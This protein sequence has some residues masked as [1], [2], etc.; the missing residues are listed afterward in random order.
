MLS[1]NVSNKSTNND[2]TDFSVLK[3]LGI[4]TRINKI[5][6]PIQIVCPS[7]DGALRGSSS[8]ASCAGIFRGSMGEFVGDFS[9]FN[10][11]WWHNSWEL[12]L[13]LRK[14]KKLGIN[15]SGWSV[16][17]LW[18][19]VFSS[20]DLMCLDFSRIDGINVFLLVEKLFLKFLI[21]IQKT[22]IMLKNLPL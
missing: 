9:S 2:I 8:H 15:I 10:L 11:Y 20:L 5:L 16:I 17:L 19:V 12:L 6:Q 1:R 18:F 3:F 4:N 13:L 7:T 14:P 21:F 22:I